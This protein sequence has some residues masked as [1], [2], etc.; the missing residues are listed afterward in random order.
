MLDSSTD[1]RTGIW[2]VPE[3]PLVISYAPA[4]LNEIRM[5][6]VDAYFSLPHGG[7]EIGG[8]LLGRHDRQRVNIESFQP[9]SCEHAMGPTFALSENDKA[10][11]QVQLRETAGQPLTRDLEIVGWYHSHTRSEICLSGADL[12]L[13]NEFFPE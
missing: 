9:V 7:M 3:C 4:I 10:R 12:E 8:L 13:Y 5:A 6:A 1:I 2:R 11:L